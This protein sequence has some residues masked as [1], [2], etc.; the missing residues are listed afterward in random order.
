MASS[1]HGEPARAGE[2]RPVMASLRRRDLLTAGLSLAGS[3]GVGIDA[4]GT[5]TVAADPPAGAKPSAGDGRAL[6]AR[7]EAKRI[8][9]DRVGKGEKVLLISGFPQTRRS[10]N[11][12][13][14]LLSTDFETIAADLP[15]FGDSGRWPG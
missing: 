6:D 11:R 14:P 1:K 9:F 8:A 10:W 4:I 5:A 2:F 15:S 7:R 13:I 12:V 3:L